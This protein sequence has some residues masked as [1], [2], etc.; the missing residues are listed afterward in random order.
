MNLKTLE[1]HIWALQGQMDT[2][3]RKDWRRQLIRDHLNMAQQELCEIAPWLFRMLREDTISVVAGTQTYRLNDWCRFPTEF[4]T[5][6][7][8]PLKVSLKLARLADRDGSRST[9]LSLGALGPMQLT[10]APATTSALASGS[11]GALSEAGTA[12]TKTGGSNLVSATHV[13]RMLRLK[14][15]DQDY[16]I[17]AV[18][19]VDAATI[20]RAARGRLYGLGTTG[21]ASNYSAANWEVSPAGRKQ[22]MI[23]GVPSVAVTLNYRYVAQPRWL[24]NDDERPEVEDTFHHFLWKR[25]A[26]LMGA[27]NANDGQHQRW[28]AESDETMEQ[29]KKQDMDTYD[30][31]DVPYFS[32]LMENEGADRAPR[33]VYRRY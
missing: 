33:D 4:W 20:D 16:R 5:T 31:E 30:S 25:A 17:T 28:K 24:I 10:W 32:T 12:F 29:L 14:G 2:A 11:V 13:G 7:Y 18:S 22:I 15:E 27:F 8:G 6:Q 26:S 19:S 23:I 1:E 9:S 21:V 3:N